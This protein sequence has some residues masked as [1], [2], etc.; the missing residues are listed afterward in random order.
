MLDISVKKDVE[1]HI[2]SC[3]KCSEAYD[4]L[5][6]SDDFAF[7][8]LA[9]YRQFCEENYMPDFRKQDAMT[10]DSREC[11]GKKPDTVVMTMSKGVKGFMF[12]YRKIAAVVCLVATITMCATV[13]PVK[14][15]ISD[16]LSIFRV[17]NIKG[18]K[19]SFADME[20]IR[21]KLAQKEEEIFVLLRA[22]GAAF[23]LSF[24]QCLLEN[25]E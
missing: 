20:E 18:F 1:K 19:V 16:A 13:Q 11:S 8:K 10:L 6:K 4:S 23:T 5:K 7:G 14:A 25:H 2:K 3:E 24:R 21:K 17:E 12:K 9:D 22:A 15:F